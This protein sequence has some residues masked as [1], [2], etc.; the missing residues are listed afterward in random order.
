MARFVTNRCHTP[1]AD[2]IIARLL[3]NHPPPSYR[4]AGVRLDTRKPPNVLKIRMNQRHGNLY[5]NYERAARYP[6][7]PVA[8]DPPEPE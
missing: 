3:P 5:L 4:F 2:R 1:H 8:P 6:W 7:F